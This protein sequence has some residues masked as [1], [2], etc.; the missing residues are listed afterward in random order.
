MA[1]GLGL[2]VARGILVADVVS[3]GPAAR[4]GLA[5]GDVI[6]AIDGKPVN[7]VGHFRNQIASS[8]PGVRCLYWSSTPGG[9]ADQN[10]LFPMMPGCS[11]FTR[12]GAMG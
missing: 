7:D 3:N 10:G 12:I 4:A 11:A 8:P 2:P 9:F 5:R 1:D 6:L